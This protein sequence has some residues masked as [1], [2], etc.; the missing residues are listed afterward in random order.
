M[1]ETQLRNWFMRWVRGGGLRPVVVV[2]LLAALFVAFPDRNFS[3]SNADAA[4]STSPACASGVGVGGT[5]SAT[6]ASTVGGHGCVVIKYISGGVAQYETFSYTG[7]EQNWTVPGGVTSA[8]FFLLGAGGGGATK[9]LG[10]DGGGGGYATGSYAVT[11]GNVLTIIVGQRGGGDSAGPGP[12]GACSHTPLKYGGGGQG[13]SC[14]GNIRG[15]SS[16]GGRSAIRLSGATTDLTTA[17]GGGG[18][19]W[20][21]AG[22]AGG[23]LDGLSVSYVGQ[24]GR[25]G[26]QLAGGA[27]GTTNN[28]L[29]TPGLAGS[30]YLG[31]RSDDEGGGGGG[32]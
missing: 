18:G 14:Y 30:A 28:N 9:A 23:G 29:G 22:G 1:L 3:L 24:E 19:G 31:G 5:T 12:R 10:G 15:F 20:G 17:G 2:A 25:G 13:G 4:P 6:V 16:G 32:G 26:T 8:N 7:A 11:P 21:K 27:G